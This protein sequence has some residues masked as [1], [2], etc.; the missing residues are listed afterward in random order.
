MGATSLSD[1]A[2]A[3][4][5]EKGFT[6]IAKVFD[7]EHMR[8]VASKISELAELEVARIAES[9]LLAPGA[10]PSTW[11]SAEEYA[12]WQASNSDWQPTIVAMS[13]VQLMADGTLIDR[14]LNTPLKD[15]PGETSFR[16]VALAPRMMELASALL[17]GRRALVFSDQCFIKPPENGGPKPY[18][19][20]N[21]YFGVASSDDIITAWVAL[22][23]AD[24]HNGA[25]RYVA[26][27]H[28]AGLVDHDITNIAEPFNVNAVPSSVDMKLEEVAPV[29]CGGVL[30]HHGAA[31]HSSSSNITPHH[32]RA[33]AIHYV[34]EEASFWD[35]S[36][37][38]FNG[39]PL[40]ALLAPDDK[41]SVEEMKLVPV[42]SDAPPHQASGVSGGA[43]RKTK[44]RL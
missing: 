12:A 2:M 21:W 16:S 4:W 20:D 35:D 33:Y 37:V 11:R 34:A 17:G 3:D 36:P 42:T 32:R 14:K 39:Y 22:D 43:L 30:F 38:A 24:E 41:Q 29:E 13:K 28:H 26:G 23:D 7:S 19:Q 5:R 8:A 27:G 9:G 25:L 1:T 18:H 6:V 40:G 10:L 15:Y 31:L 44:A